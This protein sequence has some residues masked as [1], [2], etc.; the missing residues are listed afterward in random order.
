MACRCPDA[1]WDC[2]HPANGTAER[3]SHRRGWPRCR[4]PQRG[5][6]RGS[7]VARTWPDGG[8]SAGTRFYNWATSRSC[9]HLQEKATNKPIHSFSILSFLIV[10]DNV[11]FH[12]RKVEFLEKTQENWPV[13]KGSVPFSISNGKGSTTVLTSPKGGERYTI[14]NQHGRRKLPKRFFGVGLCFEML[15]CKRNL[16]WAR[17][18][19]T[20]RGF[21]QRAR[22]TAG[23]GPLFLTMSTCDGTGRPGCPLICLLLCGKESKTGLAQIGMQ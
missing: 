5:S 11:V 19:V 14:K 17:L 6:Y 8:S 13:P 18:Q 12:A 16:T 15:K 4:P 7:W 10:F 3:G 9:P 22:I 21:S 1:P 23:P 20:L 2:L